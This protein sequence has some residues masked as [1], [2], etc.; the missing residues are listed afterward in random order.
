MD[1]AFPYFS[2]YTQFNVWDEEETLFSYKIV[3]YRFIKNF[4]KLK[5]WLEMEAILVKWKSFHA[6]LKIFVWK[7]Y[8]HK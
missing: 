7:E 4:R 3:L 5:I 8:F 1:Q 6:T 2:T